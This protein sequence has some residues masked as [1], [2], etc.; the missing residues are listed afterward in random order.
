M[1]EQQLDEKKLK[2]PESA[3]AFTKVF[4]VKHM[5]KCSAESGPRGGLVIY[6]RFLRG[7]VEEE[8]KVYNHSRSIKRKGNVE[9]FLS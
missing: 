8:S 1:G 2:D 7:K 9:V 5:L 4:K 3:K 6:E